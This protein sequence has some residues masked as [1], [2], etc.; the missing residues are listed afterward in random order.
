M[1]TAVPQASVSGEPASLKAGWLRLAVWL[2]AVAALFFKPLAALTHYAL[3]DENGSYVILIPLIVAWLFYT[4]RKQ[5]FARPTSADFPSVAALG[6]GSLAFAAIG[7]Y[8]SARLQSPDALTYF[9]IAIVLACIA[10]FA[11]AFGRNVIRQ[12]AFPLWFL[13]LITPLP[14][15]LLDRVVAWLQHGSADISAALFN[16]SGAPVL[17]EGLVFHLSTVSIEVAPECSGIRSSIALL[18]LALLVA[19]FAFRPIWKR[20]VFIAAGLL[21][22]II[23]NGVRIATLSLLANYVDPGFL[24][25]RLHRQGG[26]VFFLIGLALLI[27]VYWLLKRGEK[28]AQPEPAAKPS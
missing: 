15:F 28:N 23:K 25:G 26:V 9:T 12:G 11:F 18:I 19:R 4:E 17:R 24:Y 16:L 7:Y 13:L 2:A 6:A 21:M 20:V 22:M 8:A 3:T 5:I 27:P 14:S 10:G 1:S